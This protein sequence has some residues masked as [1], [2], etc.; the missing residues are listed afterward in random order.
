MLGIV[1]CEE[2]SLIIL[3]LSWDINV[4]IAR[5]SNLRGELPNPHELEQD[6]GAW[7]SDPSKITALSCSP[8]GAFIST[9][10][11]CGILHFLAYDTYW[12]CISRGGCHGGGETKAPSRE[13]HS[14]G[15]APSLLPKPATASNCDHIKPRVIADNKSQCRFTFQQQGLAVC[16]C[17]Q[18]QGTLGS[19]G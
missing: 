9:W 18:K 10:N 15:F 7:T 1:L 6:Q 19:C 4:Q 13:L 14:T 12:L 17:R 5:P 8:D 16:F 3:F 2:I 11:W